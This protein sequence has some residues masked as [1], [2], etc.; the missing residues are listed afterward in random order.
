MSDPA[1]AALIA[2]AS[3]CGF[4]VST[5]LQHKTAGGLSPG[6]KNPGAVLLALLR[7]PVWLA[8]SSLGLVAWTLHAAA[9][10]FGTLA[11]VQPIILLGVVFA[12]FV[13]AIIGGT[14]PGR[15]EM[16]GVVV[17]IA[18]LVAVVSTADTGA[19]GNGWQLNRLVVA[20]GLA[21]LLAVVGAVFA[22]RAHRSE[23]TARAMGFLAGSLFGVTACFMKVTGTRIEELGVGGAL[24]TGWPWALLGFGAFAL[25]LNQ[26][27]Y[28][29]S[30]LSNSMPVLN[31][32]AV[33][34]SILLGAWVFDETLPT[35]PLIIGLQVVGLATIGWGL[36]I[37]AK[38]QDATSRES[39]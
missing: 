6:V 38:Q 10:H 39:A 14:F 32:T 9:L 12:V 21:L 11:L 33:L 36:S 24:A 30:R 2:L 3:A 26:R 31:V 25:A 20:A 4:S 15:T 18:A 27:A 16:V 8:G 22:N 17:T 29:V 7:H 23:T 28:Q 35:N 13:R 34:L 1:L 37:I 19:T 5:S